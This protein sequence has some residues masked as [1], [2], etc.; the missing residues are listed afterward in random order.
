MITNLTWSNESIADNVLM[1]VEKSGVVIE[2]GQHQ[3]EKQ[4]FDIKS[5]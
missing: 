4:I 5:V 2:E 1:D 3:I